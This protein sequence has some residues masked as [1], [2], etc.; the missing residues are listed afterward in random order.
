[1]S[2]RYTADGRRKS[3]M[4]HAKHAFPCECGRVVHGNGAR[5]MHFYVNGNRA[6]GY[7]DGHQPRS[8]DLS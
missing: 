7:R 4:S 6:L 5:A 1:M 8:A 3:A 2:S